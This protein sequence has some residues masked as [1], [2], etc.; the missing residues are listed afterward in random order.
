M[1]KHDPISQE[2]EEL[3]RQSVDAAFRIHSELGPGLLESVYST[4]M[5]IE[6]RSRG[7][8]VLSEVRLPIFY[9]GY[10]IESAYRID[11][12]VNEELIIE[13]KAASSTKLPL[14][15]AQL[16][17]Y[18]KLTRKRLGLLINFNV[19]YIREGIHRMA[20]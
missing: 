5:C 20:L 3:S 12:L 8:L 18:L 16:L 17:T 19:P 6:L 11:L 15:K 2:V 4:C 14:H 10:E 9:G 13:I 7:L 1:G